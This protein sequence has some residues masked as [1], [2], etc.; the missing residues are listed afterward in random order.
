MSS[1]AKRPAAGPADEA[2]ATHK[3]A[4][5][6]PP[7]VHPA[8]I[9]PL[10]SRSAGGVAGND[11]P[12]VYWMSRDQRVRDNW[13]LLHAAQSAHGAGR[14]LAVVFNLLPSFLGMTG[15][16]HFGAFLCNACGQLRCDAF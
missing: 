11:G 8:R 13:A 6:A 3:A 16:R 15:Q 4:R 14:P 7:L 10:R 5:S 9:R 2:P 12:V 1:T